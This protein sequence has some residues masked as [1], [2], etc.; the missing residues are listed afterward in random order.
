MSK[1]KIKVAIVKA[2]F[3]DSFSVEKLVYKL[4]SKS[5]IKSLLC[6]IKEELEEAEDS[7]IS[8][9]IKEVS[10]DWFDKIKPVE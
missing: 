9:K 1:K 10:Q 6:E 5:D 8:I 7:T 3:V 2:D 4:E